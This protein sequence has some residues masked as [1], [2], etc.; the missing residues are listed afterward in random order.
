MRLRLALGLKLGFEAL[1]EAAPA[2]AVGASVALAPALGEAVG[3]EEDDA[4][5]LEGGPGRGIWYPNPYPIP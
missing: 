3:L 2:P 5:G 4:V 1:L